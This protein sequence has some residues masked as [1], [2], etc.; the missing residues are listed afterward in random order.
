MNTFAHFGEANQ[1]YVDH[2]RGEIRPGLTVEKWWVEPGK[3]ALV[4]DYYSLE[5]PK[6]ANSPA[7]DVEAWDDQ[8]QCIVGPATKEV[9]RRMYSS[10]RCL[11]SGRPVTFSA[12]D[13]TLLGVRRAVA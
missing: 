7:F 4:I 8:Q 11:M 10:A 9:F 2:I 5:N 6:E 13:H 1:E 12:D 3:I